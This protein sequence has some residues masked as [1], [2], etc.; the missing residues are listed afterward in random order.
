MHLLINRHKENESTFN[1]SFLPVSTN[2]AMRPSTIDML[3][4]YLLT[5]SLAAI[6]IEAAALLSIGL[7]GVSEDVFTSMTFRVASIVAIVCM[8]LVTRQVARAAFVSALSHR[9]ASFSEEHSN[10]IIL[11]PA[12]PDRMLVSLH[13][14]FNRQAIE[15]ARC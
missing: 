1:I 6:A 2:C 10:A 13:L 14:R 9:Y 3:R 5:A 7:F 12:C 4:A 11:S 15:C 8:V